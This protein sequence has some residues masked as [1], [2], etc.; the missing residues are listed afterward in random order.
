[1]LDGTDVDA[2]IKKKRAHKNIMAEAF[3]GELSKR[4]NQSVKKAVTVTKKA[5]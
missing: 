5:K 1:M 2:V 4:F 3:G